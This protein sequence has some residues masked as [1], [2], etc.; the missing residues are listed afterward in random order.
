MWYPRGKFTGL[1]LFAALILFSIREW[2]LGFIA[3]GIGLVLHLAMGGNWRGFLASV[4]AI[5]AFIGLITVL[6]G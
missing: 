2:T 6:Y 3:A 4:I 5:L 1:A